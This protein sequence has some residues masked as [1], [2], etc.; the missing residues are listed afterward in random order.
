M[1]PLNVFSDVTR[2]WFERAFDAPTPAQTQNLIT[3]GEFFKDY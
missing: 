1:S 3:F 2:G